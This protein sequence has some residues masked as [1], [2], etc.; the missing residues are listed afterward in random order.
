[1]STHL[2]GRRSR[3]LHASTRPRRFRPTLA[4]LETRALLSGVPA[5]W[6]VRGSGGGGALFSPQIN[7]YNPAEMFVSSDMSE[8]FHSTDGGATWRMLDFRQVQGGQGTR[9][10]YTEDPKVVYTLD[11]SSINGVD[12][13]RPDV[14]LD[15]GATWKPLANDPTG[16]G[17]F[18]LEADPANHNRLVISDYQSLYVSTDAGQTWA[19]K[20]TAKNSGAGIV[21]GGAF[22]DGA[23]IYFGTNDGLLASTNGGQSFALQ[24]IAGIP[25]GQL[26]RSFAG[27]KQGGT[28]RFVAVTDE[29]A[30]VYGGVQGYD[31]NGGTA[32]Y[33]LDLG[34]SSW[35]ARALPSGVW[36]F[37]AGMAAGNTSTMYVAGGGTAGAPTVYRSNDGGATWQSVLTTSG[38]GNVQTGWSGS[39]GDRDW[40]YGE[41]ALGF[42]VDPADPNRIIITDY[43]F[44]HA[45]T[46]GGATWKALY[47]TPAD[48]NAAGA[49]TPRGRSYHDSGLDNTTS[50][51][52]AWAD[53]THL[54]VSNS[55]TRGQVSTD[56]GQTF[57]F[58]YTGQ[59]YNSMY[60][61]AVAPNGTMYGAAGSVHDLYQ[62]TTLTD[63]RIDGA[64]GA[65]LFS[66]DQGKTWQTLHNFAHEVSWVATD[67]ANPNRLYASV[68][69]S[70]AGGIYVT[71]NLSAG[72][73]STWTK[74]ANPPR[75]EGH[76]LTVTVLNDGSIL[77]SYSGRRNSA[78]AFTASSGVFLSTDGG[79]TWLD[80][81]AAGQ[82]YWTW[83]VVVDP[84]DASQNT[85]YAG[86]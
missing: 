58:G 2:L 48:L 76:P 4:A 14:S 41:T 73:G 26:I 33:T 75:T 32:V 49:N 18:Y 44:A 21:V 63:S 8:L 59:P 56:G 84:H 47:V 83:D 77:A 60:R 25:S 34:S 16:G 19:L 54:F 1:M 11:Y 42:A 5:Q 66:T 62:S 81:S 74:L 30:D 61:V 15:G 22:W 29:S 79:Q 80:R 51:N 67:P 17:A 35:T 40:S 82:K 70:T 78:G 71:N 10:Q 9:V 65:V 23:N 38:N 39:G 72:A 28:V 27:S 52:V 37:Y 6:S 50:W 20:Y 86:V 69:H 46:D 3:P 68:V 57:G 85:W 64:T 55:D 53:A 13:Q 7:P 43:G 12:Y 36:P 24:N 31:N 45:S